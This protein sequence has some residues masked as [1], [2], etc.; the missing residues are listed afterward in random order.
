[1]KQPPKSTIKK[2][3]LEVR[4]RLLER[5]V[6]TLEKQIK[7]LLFDNRETKLGIEALKQ[8]EIYKRRQLQTLRISRRQSSLSPSGREEKHHRTDAVVE[9]SQKK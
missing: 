5:K 1:V 7:I 8:G 2:T 3:P 9:K 6:E 4:I